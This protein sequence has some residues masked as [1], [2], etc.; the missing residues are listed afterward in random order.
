MSSVFFENEPDCTRETRGDGS[1]KLCERS[2]EQ[3]FIQ[4][5]PCFIF[6]QIKFIENMAEMLGHVNL[7]SC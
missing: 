5:R 2:V 7:Q 1:A 4:T 6:W 3:S